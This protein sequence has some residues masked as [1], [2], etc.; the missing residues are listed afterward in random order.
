MPIKLFPDFIANLYFLT[1]AQ[2][3]RNGFASSGYRPHI[4]FSHS[5]YMTTGEQIFIGKDKVNPG[6]NVKAEIRILATDVFKENLEAGILFKFCE[7]DR[8]IGFG[9]ILEVTNP[10]LQKSINF[11]PATLA[12]FFSRALKFKEIRGGLF[13]THFEGKS[14]KLRMND[15]PDFPMWTLM[16]GAQSM[17]F[18]DAPKHWKIH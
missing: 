13:E 14:V 6:E 8:T 11:I 17:D 10:E 16:Y 9:E 1:S 18:D 3:G 5:N 2:G 4:K 12:N 7:G 15:F